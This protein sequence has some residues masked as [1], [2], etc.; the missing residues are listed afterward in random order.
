MCGT[1]ETSEIQNALLPRMC[2]VA[3]KRNN[4]RSKGFVMKNAWHN[5]MPRGR[6][7]FL[8]GGVS[9]ASCADGSKLSSVQWYPSKSLNLRPIISM[10]QAPTTRR[11][12]NHSV[13]CASYTFW[14]FT[15]PRI[16]LE[17]DLGS[18]PLSDRIFSWIRSYLGLD[19]FSDRIR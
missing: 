11:R 14:V 5:P 2:H 1:H 4:K 3:L 15:Y 12:M 19:P 13:S 10:Q 17:V 8:P 18:D 7:E 16:S 6:N 9:H